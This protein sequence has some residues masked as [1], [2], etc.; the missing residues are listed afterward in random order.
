MKVLAEICI[1]PIHGSISLRKEVA[2][3]HSILK[4]TGCHVELHAYGTNIE[5]DFDTIMTAIKHIHQTLHKHGTMR[6]HSSIKISSRIDKEQTLQDKIQA[7]ET[8]LE[9]PK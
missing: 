9:E 6:I 7:V 5:G 4:K 1:I 3:A 8:I 2:L